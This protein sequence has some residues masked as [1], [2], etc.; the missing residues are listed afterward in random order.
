MRRE[1]AVDLETWVVGGIEGAVALWLGEFVLG[2]ELAHAALQLAARPLRVARD[3]CG[4]SLG[5]AVPVG[6]GDHI[7]CRCVVVELE[8]LGLR[9]RS[10]EVMLWGVGGD[11]RQGA[12]S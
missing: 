8:T 2:G 10:L 3:R 1:V 6:P 7:V 9:Q 5:A 4:Q 11:V 12:P